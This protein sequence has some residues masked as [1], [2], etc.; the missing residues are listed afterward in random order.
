[1]TPAMARDAGEGATL[2]VS[3]R[4]R[5]FNPEPVLKRTTVSSG[6]KKPLANSF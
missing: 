6:V 4:S 3:S 2:E 1:M 5:Y